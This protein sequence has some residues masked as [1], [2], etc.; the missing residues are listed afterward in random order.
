MAAVLA[1]D[2]EDTNRPVKRRKANAGPQSLRQLNGV[3]EAGVPN[4]YIPLSRVS[5]LLVCIQFG[6]RNG[7]AGADCAIRRTTKRQTHP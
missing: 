6:Y 2:E 1:R 7:L 5:L 4:G 3:S